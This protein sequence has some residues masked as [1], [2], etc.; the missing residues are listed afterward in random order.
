MKKAKEGNVP[1]TFRSR[2]RSCDDE[3]RFIGVET[4]PARVAV[5]LCLHVLHRQRPGQTPGQEGPRGVS[6]KRVL[7]PDSRGA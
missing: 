3:E 2:L 7:P 5:G 6:A 1:E 4:R